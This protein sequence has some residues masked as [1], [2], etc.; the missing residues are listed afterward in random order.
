MTSFFFIVL[1]LLSSVITIFLFLLSLRKLGSMIKNYASL[2]T[3][4]D[5]LLLF[6]F[7]SNIYIRFI[8]LAV[9]IFIT[10]FS[11]VKI[12]RKMD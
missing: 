6:V 7:I 12:V 11:F 5:H 1:F 4:I 2:L 3:G 10:T 9:G 8:C